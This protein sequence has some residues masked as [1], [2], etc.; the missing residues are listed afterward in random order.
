M[1]IIKVALNNDVLVVL[2]KYN[3]L[4][5]FDASNPENITKLI[6]EIRLKNVVSFDYRGNTMILVF[7]SQ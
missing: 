3:G 1:D 5:F 4:F 2:D 7:K 6:M